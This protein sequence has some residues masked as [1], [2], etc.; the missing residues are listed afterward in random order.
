MVI[1]MLVI[2]CG[3]RST[4]CESD[5]DSAEVDY[6]Y[7]RRG[8]YSDSYRM[9]VTCDSGSDSGRY[10]DRHSNSFSYRSASYSYRDSYRV[11]VPL[12]S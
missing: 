11:T 12:W 3:V 9:K 6:S 5:S 2:A 4:L 1:G 10:S 7:S 8:S